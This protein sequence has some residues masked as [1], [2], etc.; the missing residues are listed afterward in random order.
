MLQAKN[1]AEKAK[2]PET[3]KKIEQAIKELEKSIPPNIQATKELVQNPQSE[4]A[5]R[6]FQDSIEDIRAPLVNILNY[7]I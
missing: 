7:V 1:E 2:D 6:A 3:K 4:D 5:K